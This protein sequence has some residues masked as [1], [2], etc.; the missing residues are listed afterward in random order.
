MNVHKED[1]HSRATYTQ[2][3]TT[4]MTD[5][6]AVSVSTK[7]E[8]TGAE[9]SKPDELAESNAQ[10]RKSLKQRLRDEKNITSESRVETFFNRLIFAL[11][12]AHKKS[13]VKPDDHRSV[14]NRFFELHGSHMTAD[15]EVQPGDGSG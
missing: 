11:G 15:E 3:E 6:Q 12:P 2:V 14:L 8:S 10:L 7:Q 13:P 4:A 1:F 9:V 5:A